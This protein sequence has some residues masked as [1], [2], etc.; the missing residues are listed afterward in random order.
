MTKSEYNR[1]DYIEEAMGN[2]F[3]LL[4]TGRV[5]AAKEIVHSINLQL[6]VLRRIG[7]KR[8]GEVDK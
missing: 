7:E 8:Y 5:A 3:E 4:E 1:I 6:R 2:A